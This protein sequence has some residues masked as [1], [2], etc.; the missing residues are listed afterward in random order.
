MVLPKTASQKKVLRV[1]ITLLVVM[2][3]VRMALSVEKELSV[4][5]MVLLKMTSHQ[6]MPFVLRPPAGS[7]TLAPKEPRP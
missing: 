4:K 7:L 3:L 1:K 6:T 2:L 5:L